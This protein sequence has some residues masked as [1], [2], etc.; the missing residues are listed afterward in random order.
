MQGILTR[1]KEEKQEPKG[2]SLVEAYRIRVKAGKRL[3]KRLDRTLERSC[4]AIL[5]ALE[6]QGYEGRRTK[7]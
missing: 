5:R 3:S 6:E 1:K 7:R 4:A 2:L